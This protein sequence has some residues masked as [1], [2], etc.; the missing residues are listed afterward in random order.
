M[1]AQLVKNMPN[2]QTLQLPSAPDAS[3]FDVPDLALKSLKIQA[4]Y[5]HQD[6]ILNLA[7][8]HNLKGL[9]SLAYTDVM[10]AVLI[11]E[12]CHTPY[13]HYKALFL[14]ELFLQYKHFHFTLTD[15]LLTDAQLQELHAINKDVQFLHVHTKPARYIDEQEGL[16]S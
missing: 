4:G 11:K 15:S 9:R 12:G 10:D 6:F 5:A 16:F 7:R 2:L 3:F 8:S 13:E 1:V 14:S